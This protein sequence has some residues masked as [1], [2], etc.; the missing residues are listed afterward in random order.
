MFSDNL[1]KLY[2]TNFTLKL[3]TDPYG[4]KSLF[5]LS[6]VLETKTVTEDGKEV[7]KNIKYKEIDGKK[8]YY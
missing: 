4:N 3:E 5:E 6:E 2:S 1:E 7:T 8:Y